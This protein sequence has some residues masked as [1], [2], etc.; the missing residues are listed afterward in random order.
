MTPRTVDLDRVGRNALR[1]TLLGAAGALA[2]GRLEA[3]SMLFGGLF[4]A[5]N[6][7][8][9]RL[10]VSLLIAPGASPAAASGLFVG[11]TLVLALLV[12]GVFWQFPVAPMWFAAGASMLLV[13]AVADALWLGDPVD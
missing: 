5:V 9:I 12:L 4:M 8:L 7:R 2:A 13:S 11:K 10:L 3:S 1:L 6:Y